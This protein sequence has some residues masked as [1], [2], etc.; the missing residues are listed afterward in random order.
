MSQPDLAVF[1]YDHAESLI[2]TAQHKKL[3]CLGVAL[4]V[5]GFYFFIP[6]GIVLLV[7]FLIA[8]ARPVTKIIVHCRSCP[9]SERFN[10]L[11]SK[12]LLTIFWSARMTWS[13]GSISKSVWYC[14]GRM[15]LAISS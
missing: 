5:V 10:Y 14:A 3:L 1:K 15:T 7:V 8:K 12:T 4:V 2:M 13:P 11:R 9:S 6:L